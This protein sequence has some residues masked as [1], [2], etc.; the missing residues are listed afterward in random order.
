V[1]HH[2]RDRHSLLKLDVVAGHRSAPC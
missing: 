2:L 1:A